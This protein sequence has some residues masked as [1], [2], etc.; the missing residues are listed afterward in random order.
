MVRVDGT[1]RATDGVDYL[2]KGSWTCELHQATDTTCQRIFRFFGD[3]VG[4]V[5]RSSTS[6]GLHDRVG[7]ATEPFSVEADNGEDQEASALGDEDSS[8]SSDNVVPEEPRGVT[9]G[10]QRV[11]CRAWL[12]V[13]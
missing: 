3:G 9:C 12:F 13:E 1:I 8:D 4:R 7:G 2:F 6:S 5:A 10:S 11:V